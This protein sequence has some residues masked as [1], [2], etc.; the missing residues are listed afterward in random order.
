MNS[1]IVENPHQL[2][3]FKEIFNE[4]DN[5]VNDIGWW[6]E[7]VLILT[8]GSGLLSLVSSQALTDLMGGNHQ[9]LSPYPSL[10]P[11]LKNEFIILEV[12]IF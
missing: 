7:T 9:W 2:K 1:A 6:N 4:I 10:Y 11:F 5:R 3:L 8:R 12:I